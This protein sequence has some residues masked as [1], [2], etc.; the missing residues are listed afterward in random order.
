[1]KKGPKSRPRDP[2]LSEKNPAPYQALVFIIP[3]FH[4]FHRAF[5]G[6]VEMQESSM[7]FE[8][9]VKFLKQDIIML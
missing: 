1:M 3:E 9:S 5:P 6:E 4:L 2:H 8:C 7:N